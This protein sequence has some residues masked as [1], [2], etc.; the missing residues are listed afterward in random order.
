MDFTG[1]HPCEEGVVR[2]GFVK[3]GA[4]EN[5]PPWGVE[6]SMLIF[7]KRRYPFKILLQHERPWLRFP[8]IVLSSER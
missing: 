5:R 6:K 4:R 3:G 7:E 1:S 8:R 2:C